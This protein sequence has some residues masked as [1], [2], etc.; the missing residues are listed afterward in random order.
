VLLIMSRSNFECVASGQGF[1]AACGHSAGDRFFVRDGKISFPPGTT[2]SVHALACILPQ[3]VAREQLGVRGQ[4]ELD[5][6]TIVPDSGVSAA[7]VADPH[8]PSSNESHNTETRRP[9]ESSMPVT[10]GTVNTEEAK[11][12]DTPTPESGRQSNEEL[13]KLIK[14]QVSELLLSERKELETMDAEINKGSMLRDKSAADEARLGQL[15]VQ[16]QDRLQKLERLEAL[17]KHGDYEEA[18]KQVLLVMEQQEAAVPE[19]DMMS[20]RAAAESLELVLSTAEDEL[21]EWREFFHHEVG[22]D[23][24]YREA[25]PG[26]ATSPKTSPS[27]SSTAYSTGAGFTQVRPPPPPPPPSSTRS[28]LPKLPPPPLP[29]PPRSSASRDSH[30]FLMQLGDM[31]SNAAPMKIRVTRS[32][33]SDS[34]SSAKSPEL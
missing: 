32:D 3:L 17:M 20:P 21:R 22:K 5:G 24:V 14:E 1:S 15:K 16:F 8:P 29:P 18:A 34:T 2:F 23:M 13:D 4:W 12:V 10:T 7:T 28:S 30:N 9:P 25:P 19:E 33:R 26:Y 27:P 6:F 11:E 31:S